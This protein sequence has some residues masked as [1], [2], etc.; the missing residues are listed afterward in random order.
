MTMLV[1][2]ACLILNFIMICSVPPAVEWLVFA[3]FALLAAGALLFIFAVVTLR[4]KRAN[5]LVD[6]GIYGIVRHPMYL[7]GMIM[8]FSHPFLGQ[9]WIVFLSTAVAIGCCYRSMVLGDRRNV[10]K[11]GEDYIRYMKRV[12]RMNAFLG[13]ARHLH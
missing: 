6:T 10:A 13:L 8:F 9:H 1:L 11:F 3:G 12:P 2:A 4:N 5:G 7:G